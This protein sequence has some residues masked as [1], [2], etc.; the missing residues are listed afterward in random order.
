MMHPRLTVFGPVFGWFELDAILDG[1]VRAGALRV[2]LRSGFFEGEGEPR[3][4][5]AVRASGLQPTHLVQA[6]LCRAE[7]SDQREPS[8]GDPLLRTLSAAAALGAGCVYGTTGSAGGR[9]WEDAADAFCAAVRPAVRH[10]DAAGVRLLIEPTNVLFADLSFV[11]SL[12]D[13]VVLAESAGV[14]VC[15]DVQHCWAE[16]NLRQ[17]IRRAGD[18]IGL[19]QLSDLVPGRHVPFR[20]VPG[21][22]IIPLERI[23]S[24][25]LDTGYEGLFDLELTAEPDVDPAETVAVSIDRV[26]AMLERLGV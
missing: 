14:G 1:C 4:L 11:H 10:A 3:A 26:S 25:V 15:V 23:V 6:P 16:R 22:G 17:A 8:V 9:E 24:W 12:R 5:E 19:V 2:G 13:T 20:A 7:P 21:D 18:R